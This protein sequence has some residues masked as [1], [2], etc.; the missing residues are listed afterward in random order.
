MELFRAQGEIWHLQSVTG[1]E[2][3]GS[4]HVTVTRETSCFLCGSKGGDCGS[5][6]SSCK[7]S[8]NRSGGKC[9][10]R[11]M[12]GMRGE[13]EPIFVQFSQSDSM[14]VNSHPSSSPFLFRSAE[15]LMSGQ[16]MIPGIPGGSL[17]GGAGRSRV[18]LETL[19]LNIAGF[20]P[21]LARSPWP[22]FPPTSLGVACVTLGQD[23]PK[24]GCR[25]W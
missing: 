13:Y 2:K 11:G 19:Q 25:W 12:C 14:G 3:S 15:E 22:S 18:P 16:Q 1:F 10:V 9:H 6:W 23:T 8:K 5:E 24:P 4:L 7:N 20:G 21:Y 17:R